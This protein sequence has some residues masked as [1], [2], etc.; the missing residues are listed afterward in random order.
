[1]EKDSAFQKSI[2]L[3]HVKTWMHL[4]RIIMNGKRKTLSYKVTYCMIPVIK[5]GKAN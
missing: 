4:Y 5:N 3:I 1:M 2:L